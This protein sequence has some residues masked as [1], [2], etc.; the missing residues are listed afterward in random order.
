MRRTQ[1]LPLES[2]EDREALL[3]IARASIRHGLERKSPLQVDPDRFS[4]RL[5][6]PGACFVTLR[7]SGRLRGCVGSLDATRSLVEDVAHNAFASAFRDS[8]FQPLTEEE[9]RAGLDVHL[10]I[11]TP[12]EPLPCRS[13]A[14]LLSKL[15]PGID[16]LILQDGP[17]RA[18]FLPSVWE[19]LVEPKKFLAELK[20]KAG[21]SENHWS[22]GIRFQRYRAESVE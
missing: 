20:R 18:T 7:R 19:S 17:H 3:G 8:R 6:E 13:E 21:L 5:R 10:S 4:P 11:L 9:E 14:E 1:P 12:P 2:T 15:R 22:D 16:G